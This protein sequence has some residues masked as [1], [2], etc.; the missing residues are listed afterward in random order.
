MRKLF[1]LISVMLFFSCQ[2]EKKMY[3][4]YQ[5]KCV[6]CTVAYYHNGEVTTAYVREQLDKYFIM[7]Q[8]AVAS[9]SVVNEKD[10]NCLAR[11]FERG[12]IV[13]EKNVKKT[14][15]QITLSYTPNN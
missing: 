9:I 5:V 11:I 4:K 12:K 3:I 10:S 1:I 6:E 13:Q 15:E 14:W 8:T 7:Q 2:K